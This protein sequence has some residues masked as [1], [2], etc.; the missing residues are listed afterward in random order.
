MQAA[1]DLHGD[2]LFG[3]ALLALLEAFADAHDGHET[4]FQRREDL[5]VHIFV[6]LAHG[7]ALRV[8]ENDVLTARVHEHIGRDLAG[9]GAGGVGVAVF[10]AD[11]HSGL[12][13]GANGC[14]DA[15]GGNA[16][17]HVAPTALGH[18]G[19]ELGHE[20]L[21]LG[22][23]LVHLPV[24]GDDSLTILTIHSV[25]LLFISI[26]F[27]I[28]VLRGRTG[29]SAPTKGVR[30]LLICVGADAHIGPR[31]QPVILHGAM[32]SIDPAK[33]LRSRQ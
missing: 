3:D 23:G 10:C 30:R 9:V 6:R 7:A 18:D 33:C 20:L 31:W 11:A 4:V 21:G 1:L 15:D 28:S 5:R 17:R 2:P 27:I 32:C 22:W 8:A 26:L 12:A 25:S 13:H 14:G 24:A 19:L 29:A 16:Q